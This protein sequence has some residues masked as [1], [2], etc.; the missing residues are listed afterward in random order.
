MCKKKTHEEYVA[1]VAAINPDIEVVGIYDG[2]KIKILHRCK[3]D[4]H[5]WMVIPHNI[6]KG[7]GCPICGALASSNKRTKTHEQYVK[8][9]SE[10]NPNIEVIGEYVDDC[11]K[12]LHMCKIDGCEWYAKPSNILNGK[13][14]P[15]CAGNERYGHEGYVRKVSD[16]NSNI[17]VVG[18]YVNAKT[19]ILHRCKIDK[20]EWYVAPSD[21]LQGHGCPKCNASMGE[22]IVADWLEE[23][24]I[25]YKSQKTFDDCKNIKLLPF[26]FYLPDYNVLIEYNGVQHYE[27]VDYFGGEKKFKSIIM[28][29][30][31][32]ENYCKA[33]NIK[34]FKI[35]YFEDTYKE[36]EKLYKLIVD[37]CITEGVVA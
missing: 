19:K 32:K 37:S 18:E 11:T 7:S 12:I 13:G 35:P 28:R 25:S 31:I 9:V 36:L 33:N 20:Y 24:G 2:N 34:L 10:I 23:N 6:L 5:E 21:I 14:C 29:D 27:P 1:E 30:K 22:K 16:I 15:R 17:E 26:D 4:G 3:I 8:E